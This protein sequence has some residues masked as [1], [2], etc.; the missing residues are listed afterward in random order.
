MRALKLR[1]DPVCEIR[2]RCDGDVATEVDH[3]IPFS[4]R[5]DLR[6]VM[7]NLQSTCK[8]CHVAKSN[9]ERKQR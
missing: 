5:P 4:I 1:Q 3:R 8:A 9:E 6:L 7:E 2:T